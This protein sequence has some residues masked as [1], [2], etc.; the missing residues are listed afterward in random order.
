MKAWLVL[1]NYDRCTCLQYLIPKKHILKKHDY[2]PQFNIRD[3]IMIKKYVPN[4][5][6]VRL[7]GTRQLEVSDQMDRLQ[8]VN[9]SDAHKNLPTDFIVGGLPDEQ[10][11]A[12][13]GKYINDPHILKELLV[14]DIFLH[15]CFPN[16]WF[17][18]H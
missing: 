13:K 12:R 4:F 15:E 17:K 8:K 7:T 14:I 3:L 16:L 6:V 2:V 5:R 1:I 18:C 11:F 9:I 10:I